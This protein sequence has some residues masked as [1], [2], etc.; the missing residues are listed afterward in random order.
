MTDQDLDLRE[1]EPPP[2]PSEPHYYPTHPLFPLPDGVQETKEIYEITFDR[3]DHSGRKE[4]C[5]DRFKASEL[6]SLAQVIDMF[7]GGTYQ[8][9]AFNSHGNF[10]RWTAE[11][12]KI[13]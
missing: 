13:R 8:F 5:P 2:V 6:T 1:G 3:W 10:S 11:K 9:I 4:R 7:G 12:D